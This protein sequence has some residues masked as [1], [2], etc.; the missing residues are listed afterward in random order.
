MCSLHKKHKLVAN[1]IMPRFTI[2]Q[3]GN[4]ELEIKKVND[5][6]KISAQIGSQLL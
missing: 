2:A 5:M 4:K 3:V 6:K 1:S